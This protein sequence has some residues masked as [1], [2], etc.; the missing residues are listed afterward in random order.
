[1]SNWITLCEKLANGTVVTGADSNVIKAAEISC[2]LQV[3]LFSLPGN[4]DNFIAH[5]KLCD[6]VLYS[7]SNVGCAYSGV[8]V[9]DTAPYY[10][11]QSTIYYVSTMVNLNAPTVETRYFP[12]GKPVEPI[13]VNETNY[14]TQWLAESDCMPSQQLVGIDTEPMA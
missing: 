10:T 5:T 4:K 1:M 2:P 9:N 12:D 6:Y 14:H 11:F 3:K 8:A 7:D 13:P